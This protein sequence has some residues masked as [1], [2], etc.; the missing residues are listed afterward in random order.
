MGFLRQRRHDEGADKE[1]TIRRHRLR[2]S[3]EIRRVTE[4]HASSWDEVVAEL[5]ASGFGPRAAEELVRTSFVGIGWD[6]ERLRVDVFGA[7]AEMLLVP[8]GIAERLVETAADLRSR[9]EAVLRHPAGSV[10]FE[11]RQAS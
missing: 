1:R 2:L 7:G 9:A 10:A 3:D 4:R 6:V 11:H 8:R 5:S